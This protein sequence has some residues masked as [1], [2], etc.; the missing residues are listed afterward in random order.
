MK[1]HEKIQVVSE[2]VGRP[3][4]APAIAMMTKALG[5][6]P[7][8]LVHQALDRVARECRQVTLAEI[9]SRL[10]GAAPGPDEAWAIVSKAADEDATVVWTD[11]I[12]GAHRAVAHMTDRVA[13]RMAFRDVYQRLVAE[14]PGL[15]KW[16][17]SAGHDAHQREGAL[18]EAVELGRL[19]EST[20]AKWYLPSEASNVLA[21]P[22]RSSTVDDVAPV[23]FGRE[24]LERL[25]RGDA[26]RGTSTRST[27]SAWWTCAVTRCGS[28]RSQ[29]TSHGGQRRRAFERARPT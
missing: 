7:E 1:I 11:E 22:S 9:T 4:S 23:S 24:Q 15:P 17:V 8:P 25:R 14:R 18:R 2:M 20:L 29:S 27:G 19:P 3:M 16:W 6:Y 10:P 28:T 12:A 21:L 13:A 26:R 5:M